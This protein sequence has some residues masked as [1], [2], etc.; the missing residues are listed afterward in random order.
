MPIG[1]SQRSAAIAP[2]VTLAID[3]KAKEMAA[4]GLDVVG[5]GA[6]EPDY[7]TPAHIREAAKQALDKGMTKYTPSSGTLDLRKA[8][9]EKLQRDQ[10]LSY[11]PV[12]IVVSN[13]AKHSLSQVFQ[14]IIDPGDEVLVPAPCWVSYTEMVSMAGGVPVVV[15]GD[16]K[17]DFL[18]NAEQLRPYVTSKT[19]ALILNSPNNPNGC[20]WGEELLRGI[21]QLAV[22]NDFYVV[23]DEIYEKLIYDG[24]RH[25]SIA[26]LGDDIFKRTIVIAGMSKAY[27]MT[28]WRIGF[29]AGPKDVMEAL[30]NYQSQAASNPNSIAQFASVEG[31][32]GGDDSITEMAVEFDRRRRRLVERINAIAFI[33]CR[34][35]KGAFYVMMNIQGLIGKSYKGRK[36]EGSMSLSEMLLSEK[37][38]A[39]VPGK[40]FE[41]DGYVRLSF[42]TS[43]ANID[44]GMDRIAEF[45][46]ELDG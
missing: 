13:G 17:D 30:S 7:I 37:L 25:V 36:I 42:A 27:A 22:E 11:K 40:A 6:G 3:A 4:S 18:V 12:E 14:T 16:E 19:K 43:M 44:K 46:G 20:V 32:R 10:G 15:M 35:P 9:C 28:G 39:V 29:A 1:I 34:M 23:S 2:S 24:E 38:V 5:F 41:A 31:L 21:A 26:S 45:I 33:S 8:I